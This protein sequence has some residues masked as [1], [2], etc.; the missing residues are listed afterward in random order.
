MID[1]SL[2]KSLKDILKNEDT[3]SGFSNIDLFN[4][5][6]HLMKGVKYLDNQSFIK[7]GC[8]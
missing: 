7:K 8:V 2:E 4:E 3:K 5:I 6:C 1:H